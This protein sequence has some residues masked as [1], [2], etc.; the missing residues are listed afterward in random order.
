MK[1]SCLLTLILIL[2]SASMSA[3]H[4]LFPVKTSGFHFSPSYSHFNTDG[5]KGILWSFNAGYTVKGRFTTSLSLGSEVDK[6]ITF[7]LNEIKTT[8]TPIGVGLSYLVLKQEQH[9]TLLSLSIDMGYQYN[10]L[11]NEIVGRPGPGYTNNINTLLY[12]LSVYRNFHVSDQFTISASIGI[13]RGA[14]KS[15]DDTSNLPYSNYQLLFKIRKFYFSPVIQVLEQNTYF[16]MM[17]GW[18]LPLLSK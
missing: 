3:Q 16:T 4:Y 7:Q 15:D 18:I 6:F 13:G 12:G 8:S 5:L 11:S 14:A 1:N 2:F 17:A 9:H 10:H